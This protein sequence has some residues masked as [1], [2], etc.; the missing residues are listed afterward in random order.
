MVEELVKW[1]EL[2][3][4]EGIDAALALAD[5]KAAAEA[6]ADRAALLD[7]Q[8]SDANHS[9]ERVELIRKIGGTTSS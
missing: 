1:A 6:E 2:I 4:A 3:V 7:V 8:G 9:E 5:P